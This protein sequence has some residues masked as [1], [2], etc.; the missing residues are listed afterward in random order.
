MP[1]TQAR[2]KKIIS[3]S[4]FTTHKCILAA[5][6][7]QEIRSPAARPSESGSNLVAPQ[8]TIQPYAEYSWT[9]TPISFDIWNERYSKEEYAYGE[10][11]NEYL[12]SILT[13]LAPGTILFPA[14]GEGRNAVYAAT[15]GWKVYAFDQSTAGKEKALALA[16]KNGV[17]I[18]YTVADF[19]TVSYAPGQFDAIAL[20]Y[21]H[22]PS[23]KRAA[24]HKKLDRFLKPGG[25]LILEAFSK[26][27]LEYYLVN[28]KAGGPRD[29]DLLFSCEEIRDDFS[30]YEILELR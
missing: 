25:Y 20:I 12:K 11:P 23:G 4:I 27:H 19:D 17:M 5:G 22:I 3:T 21:A 8:E 2:S 30:S 18:A 9:M 15:I 26:K 7:V 1:G 6:Y 14:E 13:P 10:L 16:R 24:Y 29:I 28:E